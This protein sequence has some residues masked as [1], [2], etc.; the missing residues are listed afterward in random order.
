[1]SKPLYSLFSLLIILVTCYADSSN[2]SSL[3]TP[4][5]CGNVS[6]RYPFWMRSNTT[7]AGEYCGYPEFGIECS[8]GSKAVINLPRN[9]YYVTDIN[10]EIHSITLIDIDVLGQSCPRAR[11]NVTLDNL[12]LDFNSSLDL[13]LNFYFNCSSAP[14]SVEPIGCWEIRNDSRKSYV[15]PEGNE[16]DHGSDWSCGDHVVVTVKHNEIDISTTTGLLNGFGD[17]MK[18]GFVLDWRRAVD[19]ADCELSG[20]QCVYNQTTRQS[21]CIC[22]NGRFAAKSCKKGTLFLTC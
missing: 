9:K 18:K 12:P 14:S 8:E 3:C 6:I 4:S 20:G 17:A 11:H 15:F 10:Y 2:T 5:V 16:S 21:T 7:V 22:A 13:K 19:C 1:M